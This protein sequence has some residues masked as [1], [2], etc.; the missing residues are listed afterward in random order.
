MAGPLEGRVDRLR[1]LMKRE[2]VGVML[3]SHPV[4]IRYL[5]G[6]SGEDSWAVV[7]RGGVVVLSD[8]RFEEE[9]GV[10]HRYVKTVMRKKGLA[11]ELAK[12]V[13]GKA[14][15]RG[16][17]IGIQAEHVTL[18]QRREVVKWVGASRL[19]ETTGMVAG[20][21]VVKDEIEVGLISRAIKIQESAYRALL[22][23]MKPGV[24]ERAVA[25]KLEYEMRARG[26]D[27]PSFETIVAS[28][29]NG[30]LPHYFPGDAK[31]RKNV[32]VLIDF[33]AR[34]QGYCGDL[35]RVVV[36]GKMPK[37]MAEVYEVVAAAQQ[38]GIGAIKPGAKLA[39]VDAAAR[40]VIIDAGYGDRF[41]HGLGHGIGLE[42]H[43]LPWLNA[44]FGGELREGH[45]VTVE[46]GVY[47]P[48][49]GGV[50]LEDDI[51]VTGVGRRK[52]SGLPV[53]LDTAI[54]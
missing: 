20:L 16:A 30:S 23:W 52:L 6:F 21:R 43:E 47:L 15:K 50:R 28:G 18:A 27:G 8:S 2:S 14:K 51:L 11:E 35:T 9:L 45:V 31:V 26:A 36:L 42:I 44:R 25:A 46:P 49:V 12:V 5:T 22:K 37:R 39:E 19:K 53:G 1:S 13:G 40:D 29:A 4:D 3:V 41:G 38:A 24:T 10:H 17:R 7:T 54:I 48:G 33:G 32:P 34:Y